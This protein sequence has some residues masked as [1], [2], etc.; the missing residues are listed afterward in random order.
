M[1]EFIISVI[2][3]FN[4]NWNEKN[5]SAPFI[6]LFLLGTYYIYRTK[7]EEIKE[8]FVYPVLIYAVTVFNPFIHWILIWKIGF[9][10]R[11]HRFFWIMPMVFVLS[12]LVVDIIFQVRE[13]EKKCILLFVIIVICFLTGR[14]MYYEEHY[15]TENIYKVKDE[16]LQISN[17]LNEIADD[18]EK[19]VIINNHHINFMIRQYDPSICLVT[20]PGRM[21]SLG[22]VTELDYANN[23][24]RNAN[25]VIVGYFYNHYDTKLDEVYT[26]LKEKNVDYLVLDYKEDVLEEMSFIEMEAICDSFYIYK[27]L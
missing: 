5:I 19:T 21:E 13:K 23:L 8:I 10:G 12:W 22:Q 15:R 2:Q 14:P 26:A 4:M 16:T 11:S 3:T 18:Q 6:T 24:Q 27:V 9:S 7:K 17:K 20:D 25:E 1:R